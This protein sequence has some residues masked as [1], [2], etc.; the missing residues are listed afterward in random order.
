MADLKPFVCAHSLIIRVD[1]DSSGLSGTFLSFGGCHQWVRRVRPREG[2]AGGATNSSR[3]LYPASSASLRSVTTV[4][5][6]RV[7]VTIAPNPSS[8]LQYL[9]INARRACNYGLA[10]LGRDASS[11]HPN[12]DAE[13]AG[14]LWRGRP[15]RSGIPAHLSFPTWHRLLPG[16]YAVALRPGGLLLPYLLQHHM[17][18]ISSTDHICQAAASVGQVSGRTFYLPHYRSKRPLSPC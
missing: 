7:A 8:P 1:I 15:M 5:Y 17:S 6:T 13:G 2:Q 4:S 9:K 12:P 16:W 18:T 10:Q 11:V 14:V 3:Q